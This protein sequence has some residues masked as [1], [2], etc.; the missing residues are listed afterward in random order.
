MKFEMNDLDK[1]KFCLGLHLAH[2]LRAFSY[3]NWLM[4]KKYWRN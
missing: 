2:L 3:I 4:S 1:T